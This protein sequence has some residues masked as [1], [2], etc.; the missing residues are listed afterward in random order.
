MVLFSKL[1]SFKDK[2][3]WKIEQ[4][5]RLLLFASA[6]PAEELPL[7]WIISTGGTIAERI[8]PA[9]GAEVPAS[10][11]AGPG[12]AGFLAGEAEDFF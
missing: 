5:Y 7:V 6:A 10:A 3:N 1:Y 2:Y 9:N 11:D 12:P 8:N 4:H